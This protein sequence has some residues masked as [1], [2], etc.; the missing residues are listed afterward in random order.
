MKCK[1]T[2]RPKPGDR[3]TLRRFA[4]WPTTEQHKEHP[5]R[6][7][8]IWLERYEVD[9]EYVLSWDGGQWCTEEVRSV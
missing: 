7:R 9:Q 8:C 3:R 1:W 5:R 2:E 4:W 6:S